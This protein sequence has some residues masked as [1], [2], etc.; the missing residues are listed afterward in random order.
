MCLIWTGHHRL[1][2]TGAVIAIIISHI[3][4]LLYFSIKYNMKKD[5]FGENG[6]SIDN[7]FCPDAGGEMVAGYE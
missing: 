1:A 7:Y 2:L 4:L 6:G 3:G 5:I